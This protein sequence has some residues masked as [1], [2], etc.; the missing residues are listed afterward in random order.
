MIR[1]IGILESRSIAKGVEAC[2]AMLKTGS[3]SILRSSST[4]PGKYMTIL[5][6]NISDVE[7]SIALGRNL[8]GKRYVDHLVLAN[9]EEEVVKAIQGKISPRPIEALGMLEYLSVTGAVYGADAALK[10]ADVGIVKMKM[11]FALG[12]KSYLLV[13]GRLAAVE[14][15]IQAGLVQSKEHGFVFE[16]S[17]IPSPHEELINQLG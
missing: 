14:S 7:S 12:G 4:C 10:A 15:A 6:G 17:L 13:T 16:S 2:D 8:L 1:S 3:V 11:G 9:V 5:T